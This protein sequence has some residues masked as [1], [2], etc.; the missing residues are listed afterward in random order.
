[1]ETYDKQVGYLDHTNKTI[2]DDVLY[3]LGVALDN[4]YRF[5]DGFDKFKK[6]LRRHLAIKGQKMFL[7]KDKE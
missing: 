7:A 4:K 6:R 1:M 2:I 3:G 5:A